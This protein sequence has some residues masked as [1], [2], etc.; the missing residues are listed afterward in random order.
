[1]KNNNQKRGV[2]IRVT[3]SPELNAFLLQMQKDY[4][5]AANKMLTKPAAICLIL[6]M[7]QR[8]ELSEYNAM[9]S[10]LTTIKNL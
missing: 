9:Q 10:F 3:L 4:R 2:T 1:M 6:E 5:E 7:A 8:G